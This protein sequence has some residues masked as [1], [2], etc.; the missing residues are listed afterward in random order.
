MKVGYK[1]KKYMNGKQCIFS[2]NIYQ[3]IVMD[4]RI[5]VQG[6]EFVYEIVGDKL[7]KLFEIPGIDL[8]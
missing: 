8:S 2:S 7:I 1:N 5:I 4:G 3:S 6:L